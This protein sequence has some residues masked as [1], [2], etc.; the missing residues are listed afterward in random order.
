MLTGS[1]VFVVFTGTVVLR[2]VLVVFAGTVMLASSVV[3]D[4]SVWFVELVVFT[5]GDG[6]TA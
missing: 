4:E 6:D 5:T 2:V 3:L 1:V